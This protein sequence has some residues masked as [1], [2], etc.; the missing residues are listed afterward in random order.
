[1]G[2]GSPTSRP[3]R[4]GGGGGL[5]DGVQGGRRGVGGDRPRVLVGGAPGHGV[6]P[7]RP[8]RGRVGE[9]GRPVAGR[10]R[11]RVDRRRGTGLPRPVRVGRRDVGCG[12]AARTGQC[13]RGPA[14]TLTSAG[15][16]TLPGGNGQNGVWTSRRGGRPRRVDRGPG[17]PWA[18]SVRR[19]DRR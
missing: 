14:T 2:R 16:P 15:R 19:R 4:P 10:G 9:G 18:E 6:E 1:G 7:P 11:G 8:G 12:A 13:H 17:G 5:G 3:R